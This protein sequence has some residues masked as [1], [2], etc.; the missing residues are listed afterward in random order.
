MARPSNWVIAGRSF[1]EII[2]NQRFDFTV[3]K[4]KRGKKQWTVYWKAQ[5]GP[6]AYF[7]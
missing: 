7:L 1:F 4:E 3:S 2:I 5:W 6:T